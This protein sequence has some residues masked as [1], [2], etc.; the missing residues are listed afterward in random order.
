M[1]LIEPRLSLANEGRFFIMRFSSW[2]SS[3]TTATLLLL[4]LASPVFS[5]LT[6]ED[7]EA[8][9]MIIKEDVR[10]IIKEE[11]AASE[12]RMKE[13]VDL[14]IQTVNAKID[15]INTRIEDLDKQL[16]RIWA[17]IIALIGLIAAAIAIPQIM[18]AYKDISANKRGPKDAKP[19]NIS[20]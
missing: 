14:K 11:I 5:E 16:G 20:A 17:V 12:K 15:G 9:R 8:I 19:E 10:A 4:L 13:H 7:I 2:F 3:C 1:V 6:K 18:V